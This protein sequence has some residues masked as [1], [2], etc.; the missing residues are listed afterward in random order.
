M[1][2]FQAESGMKRL[3]KSRHGREGSQLSERKVSES[4]PVTK[5]ADNS[6]GSFD[7]AEFTLSE[8]RESNGLRPG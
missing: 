3:G 5:P 6:A 8:Q 4:N 7:F 2:S 1:L